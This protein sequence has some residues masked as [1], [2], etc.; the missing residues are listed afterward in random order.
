MTLSNPTHEGSGDRR[1]VAP[2]TTKTTPTP[3]KIRLAYVRDAIRGSNKPC[4]DSFTRRGDSGRAGWL[5]LQE[6]A[7]HEHHGPTP[8]QRR[9]FLRTAFFSTHFPCRC[10][11]RSQWRP[12][13]GADIAVLYIAVDAQWKQGRSTASSC[14]CVECRWKKAWA[15]ARAAVAPLIAAAK[16]YQRPLSACSFH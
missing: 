4:N 13:A 9:G 12:A 11:Q 16:A 15:A 14:V 8:S 5:C 10:V 3:A 7:N 1:N 6:S 2:R